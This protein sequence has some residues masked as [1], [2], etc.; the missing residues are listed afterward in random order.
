MSSIIELIGVR[1][2]FQNKVEALKGIDLKVERGEFLGVMGPSGSGKS[3]LLH[4]MGGIEKPTEGKVF[5]E[6]EEISSLSEDKLSMLRRRRISYVFQFFYLLEDFTCLEN[7]TLIGR[8]S[9][10]EDT[11]EKARYILERLGLKDKAEARPHELSGGQQQRLALG[12]ALMTSAEIIIAD[13]P[14]GNLDK[15]NAEDVFTLLKELNEEGVTV[16]VATHNENLSKHFHRIVYLEDG[17]IV[18]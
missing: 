12:R 10:I 13:E 1:K 14:T 6:G 11:E 7:L 15:R 5:L 9:G 8:I 18:S 16:V 3:T 4:I 2:V 17:R